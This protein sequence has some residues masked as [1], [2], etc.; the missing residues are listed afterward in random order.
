MTEATYVSLDGAVAINA[1]PKTENM[2]EP[3]VRRIS[4]VAVQWLRARKV[5][6]R[7]RERKM[8]EVRIN[9]KEVR[10]VTEAM[11]QW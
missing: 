3:L 10:R 11:D 7:G 5:E 4:V 6:I 9:S 8:R 2:R 1:R